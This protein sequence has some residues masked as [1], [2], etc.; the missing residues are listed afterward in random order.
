MI[1]S[2][3]NQEQ[4]PAAP[5]ALPQ[6]E[7]QPASPSLGFQSGMTGAGLLGVIFQ[8]CESMGV[9]DVQIRSELPVYIETHKGM[10]CLAH[11]GVLSSREVYEIYVELL[12]NRESANHGFGEQES[13]NR[14]CPLP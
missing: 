5:P 1:S 14:R 7:A 13:G 9:S 6:A 12:R 8:V 3:T 10:E 11:L 4:T 2:T